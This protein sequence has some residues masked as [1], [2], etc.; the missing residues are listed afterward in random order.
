MAFYHNYK[1]YA[2]GHKKQFCKHFWKHLLCWMLQS[3]WQLKQLLYLDVSELVAAKALP[4]WRGSGRSRNGLKSHWIRRF[5]RDLKEFH[6]VLMAAT[7]PSPQGLWG[8]WISKV[9]QRLHCLRVAWRRSICSKTRAWSATISHS[10]TI[11]GTCVAMDTRRSQQ[12]SDGMF[13]SNDP[14]AICLHRPNPPLFIVWALTHFGKV[15]VFRHNHAK[16]FLLCPFIF[17]H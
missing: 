10:L 7:G 3:D 16:F 8:Q 5:Q 15:A 9:G 14:T 1:K 4:L 11:P 2:L 17:H 12:S 6:P 13:C